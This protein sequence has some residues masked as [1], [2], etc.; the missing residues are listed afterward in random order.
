MFVNCL[1]EKGLYTA[2]ASLLRDP[3]WAIRAGELRD[4][5][6]GIIVIIGN[7]LKAGNAL[8]KKEEETFP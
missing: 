7:L 6:E 5:G 1:K 8:K 3:G 2:R 4:W